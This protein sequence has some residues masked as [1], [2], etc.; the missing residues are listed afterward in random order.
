[1][2]Y[3][4]SIYLIDNLKPLRECFNYSEKVININRFYDKKKKIQLEKG[5]KELSIHFAFLYLTYSDGCKACVVG[6]IALVL[7]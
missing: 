7:N 3:M 2:P 1:M 5:R 6:F 4:L